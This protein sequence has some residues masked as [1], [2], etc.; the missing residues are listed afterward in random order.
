MGKRGP[1]PGSLA[2]KKRILVPKRLIIHSD[3]E[4]VLAQH[5]ND[6]LEDFLMH[7]EDD[8]FPMK[9]IETAIILQVV[10]ATETLQHAVIDGIENYS[11]RVSPS[12]HIEVVEGEPFL[13]GAYDL[14]RKRGRSP[15]GERPKLGGL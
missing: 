3:H 15:L 14:G 12:G 11:V 8:S 10:D 1:Q 7:V 9:A 6:R 4:L 5:L 13:R 2:A